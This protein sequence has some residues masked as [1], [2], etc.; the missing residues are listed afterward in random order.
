MEKKTEE[1]RK[2]EWVDVSKEE[3]QRWLSDYEAAFGVKLIRDVC[4]IFEPPL[5]TYNDFRNY[6]KWPSSA[7]AKVVLYEDSYPMDPPV[8]NR[9]SIDA[10]A[11]PRS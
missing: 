5:V 3:F 4:G 9:Y 8:M 1:S 2:Q 11:S 10:S 6:V 7:V